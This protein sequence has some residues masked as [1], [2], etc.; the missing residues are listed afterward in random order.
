MN[1]AGPVIRYRTAIELLGEKGIGKSLRE[2]L[3]SSSLVQFWLEHLSPKLGRNDL[4]GAKTENYENVMGKLYEFGLRKGFPSLDEKTEPFRQWLKRE[5]CRPNEGYLPV[6][7]RTLVAAFLAMTGYSDDEA[8]KDWVQRRLETV[9]EFA[10]KGTLEGAYVPQDSFPG[11]PK[12]FK[13]A[14]LLNP[15]LYPNQEMKLPWIHDINAFLH[16]PHIMEDATLKAKV[17]TIIKFT[18][19][20]EYQKLP[21]GYGVVRHEPGRY[22]AMGWSVHLPGYFDSDVS[23]REFGRLLLLLELFGRSDAARHHVWY[24]RLIDMLTCFNDEEDLTIFPRE[25]LPEKGYGVWVL[26]VRMGLEENR[27][28]KRAITC[29]S[30]FR[31][32]RITSQMPEL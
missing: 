26:G 21:V 29:E 1:N 18:L 16:S 11:F 25:F 24:Q 15:E 23:G 6:F 22:Y 31:F 3:V 32:L 10:K 28:T 5:I 27:R 17:E 30:T 20:P 12:A 2:N 14:P 19:T 8:V 4:H 13:N 9:Y 7:Y